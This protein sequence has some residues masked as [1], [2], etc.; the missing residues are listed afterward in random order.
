[1]QSISIFIPGSTRVAARWSER[2]SPRQSILRRPDSSRQSHWRRRETPSTHHT[3]QI[4]S[5]THQDTA[6]VLD[7]KPGLLLNAAQDKLIG[8]R[9][10]RSALARIQT[11]VRQRGQPESGDPER[12]AIRSIQAVQSRSTSNS[13]LTSGSDCQIIATPDQSQ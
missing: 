10:D 1:M 11:V 3:R 8:C 13:G 4:A 6:N 2:A 12:P 9:I 5:A 7:G